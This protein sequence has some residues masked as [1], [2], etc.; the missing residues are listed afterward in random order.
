MVQI[1]AVERAGK[2]H[3]CPDLG[4]AALYCIGGLSGEDTLEASDSQSKVF[5]C[6]IRAQYLGKD[7]CLFPHRHAVYSSNFGKGESYQNEVDCISSMKENR[8]IIKA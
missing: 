7:K 8:H 3:H 6:Q 2:G 4:Q 5:L 1:S